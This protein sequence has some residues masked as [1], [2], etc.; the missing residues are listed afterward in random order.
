MKGRIQTVV[1]SGVLYY[2]IVWVLFD[3]FF[4][5]I[6]QLILITL[7]CMPA[8]YVAAYAPMIDNIYLD[9]VVTMMWSVCFYFEMQGDYELRVFRANKEKMIADKKKPKDNFVK[10]GVYAMCR[11]PNFFGEQGMWLCIWIFSAYTVSGQHLAMSSIGIVL[12]L[13]L[14][15]A[16]TSLTESIAMSKYPEYAEYCKTTPKFIPDPNLRDSFKPTAPKQD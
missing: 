14:F 4:V 13:L 11:H 16:S 5:S 8:Y 12:L 3:L 9:H 2:F 15:Q 10:T 6:Y 1:G 7:F